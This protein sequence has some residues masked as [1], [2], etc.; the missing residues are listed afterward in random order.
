MEPKN[1]YKALTDSDWIMAMQDELH[2]FERNQV[3]HLVQNQK[4]ELSL[5]PSGCSETSWTSKEYSPETRHDWLFKG[6][7]RKKTLIMKRPLH[8]LQ[9]LRP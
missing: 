6:T 2:Q 3:W 1:V 7:I 5:A 4:I 8:Q 9:E